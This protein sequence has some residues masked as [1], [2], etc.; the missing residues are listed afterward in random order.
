M[1]AVQ[2]SDCGACGVEWADGGWCSLNTVDNFQWRSGVPHVSRYPGTGTDGGLRTFVNNFTPETESDEMDCDFHGFQRSV[3]LGAILATFISTGD[4]G[5]LQAQSAGAAPRIQPPPLASVRTVVDP[6][7]FGISLEDPYRWLESLGDTNVRAWLHEQDGFTRAVLRSLPVRDSIRAELE[8]LPKR[9]GPMFSDPV[10]T[11]EGLFYIATIPGEAG[12]RLFFRKNLTG[13]ARSIASFTRD[14]NGTLATINSYAPSPDGRHVAY[15]MTAGGA[16][17]G[18]AYVVE[19][20]TGR[21]LPDSIPRF[22]RFPASQATGNWLPGSRGFAYVRSDR[23]GSDAGQPIRIHVLGTN[24]ADDPAVF[25]RGLSDAVKFAED[26]WISIDFAAGSRYAVAGYFKFRGSVFYAVPVDSISGASTPWR[27]IT[28]SLDRANL[29]TMHGD[30]LWVTSWRDSPRR[31]VRRFALNAGPSPEPVVVLAAGRGVVEGVTAANDAIYA[32]LFDG[33]LSRI[34]RL[35][36]AGGVAMP[37]ALAFPGSISGRVVAQSSAPGLVYQLGSWTHSRRYFAFLPNRKTGRSLPLQ[38]ASPLDNV[39]DLVAEELKV[40]AAD[41]VEI[42][43]S[44]VY[45]RGVR[46]DGSNPTLLTFYASNGVSSKSG[47]VS[48]IF[49]LYRRGGIFATC[50][51]R[52]GGEHGTEWHEAARGM[53]KETS[54]SDVVACAEYLVRN[55]YTTP[56]RLGMTSASAGAIPLM[57]AVTA[58]PDLF[59][60]AYV[61]V[62]LLDLVGAADRFTAGSASEYPSTKTAAEFRA[63]VALSPYHRIRSSTRYPAVLLTTGINDRR[64]PAWHSAK[65]AARLQAANTGPRPIMLQVAWNSGHL[66]SDGDDGRNELYDQHAFLVWQLTERKAPELK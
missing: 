29:W 60:A 11:G 54:T 56:S 42:P 49:P 17:I 22:L 62:G 25:G 32:T 12:S 66:G 20:A 52:G 30:Y 36:H 9:T 31:D 1:R 4:R 64:V 58:R 50:H 65:M 24:A 15:V 46:R 28:D 23:P 14:K 48:S 45:R 5:I 41:G 44:L 8:A 35:P 39:L 51:A 63:L 6:P 37:V 10:K 18:T 33:G 3:V 55:N 40:R 47:L 13:T 16:E 43:L 2:L 21:V 57:G 7:R 61:G 38:T 34:V 19:I 53:T 59:R 27:Q 26:E